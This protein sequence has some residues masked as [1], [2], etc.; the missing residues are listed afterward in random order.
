MGPRNEDSGAASYIPARPTL[1]RMRDAIQQCHGCDLYRYATQAILG[2]G[3]AAA[4][5]VLV[6]EQPGAK[7]DLA[8][9]P[10][11]GPAGQLLDRAL[12]EAGIAGGDVFVTN[13]VK[14]F[15]FEERGKR[16][17][18][19]KPSDKEI[20]ACKPWL[21]AELSLVKPKVIVCLGATATLAL[22]GKAHHVLADRGKFFTQSDGSRITTTLHPSAVLR[23]PDT[24]RR[25]QAYEA[26][27]RDLKAVSRE[28]RA[29]A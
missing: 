3:P 19:K 7:E 22:M 26:F 20:T 14:H 21:E 25:H 16:R 28:L 23:A 17:I 27:V 1:R 6:G 4:R 2:E 15:K 9:H 18:H 12:E 24:A 10:F 29:R 5:V 11:V 8:G 13:A